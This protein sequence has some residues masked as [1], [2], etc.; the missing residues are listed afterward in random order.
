MGRQPFLSHSDVKRQ[1]EDHVVATMMMVHKALRV[2]DNLS[3]KG[4]ST[5]VVDDDVMM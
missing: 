1:G 3:K 4:I 5:K 2:A